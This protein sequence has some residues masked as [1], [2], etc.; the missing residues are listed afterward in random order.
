MSTK[1]PQNKEDQEIDLLQIPQKISDF[2]GWINSSIFK[3]IQFFVQNKVLVLALILVGFGMGWYL[4]SNNKSYDNQ[5]IVV[6]NF[7]SVDYLYSKID[8]LQSKIVSG[9]TVFLKKVVGLKQPKTIKKIEI[10]PI[11]DV[12]RFIEN[13]DRNFDL[14]KLMA[15]DGDIKKVLEDNI[16]SKNYTHHMIS[17]TTNELMD[18]KEMVQPILNYLNNSDYFGKI[19]VIGLKNL[20]QEIAQNDT[21][22]AQINGVLNGFSNN[23]NGDKKNDKLVYYNENIQLN[24]V[25][26]TKQDLIEEQ[27]KNRI[28]LVS[29]DKIIK[30]ISNTLNIRSE[31]TVN[32]KLK[33]IFPLLFIF[34]FTCIRLFKAFYRKQAL[35][36]A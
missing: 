23:V 16:T 2:F 22:I 20:K 5:I 21:I 24:D 31:K 26:K 13:K 27:G 6:P 4:D 25:I 33:F 28:K 19:Q 15:E 34:L 18:D 7:E 3:G 1:V 10:K 9:D 14:I 17:F 12:Y 35:K 32:G 30:E 11:A 36:A 29:Y 8:L